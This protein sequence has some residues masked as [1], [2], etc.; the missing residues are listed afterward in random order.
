M[1]LKI[2]RACDLSSISVFPPHSRRVTSMQS[3]VNTS[4][5]GKNKTFSQGRPT[6]AESSVFGRSQPSQIHPQ[7]QQSFSQGM[8][9]SQL[10]QNSLEDVLANEQGFNSQDRGNSAKKVS[11]LAPITY[12]QESQL[13]VSRSSNNVIRK[14]NSNSV[15]ESRCPVSEELEHR[16]GLMETSVNRMGIIL[17]SVESDV[18]QINKAVKEVSI[19]TEGIRQKMTVHDNAMQMMMKGD[20]EIKANLDASL[21]VIPNQLRKGFDHQKLQE[22]S[23]EISKLPNLI[24]TCLLRFKAELNN[25]FTK[26]LQVVVNSIKLPIDSQPAPT[27][28]PPERKSCISTISKQSPT[29]EIA[30]AA[31]KVLR[32]SFFLKM[33]PENRTSV[34]PK[35]VSFTATNHKSA[36]KHE[37]QLIE[38]EQAIQVIIDSDEE[39]DG[40]F[41]CLLD[42]KKPRKGVCLADDVEKQTLQILRKARRRKRKRD[43]III[44]V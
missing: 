41:S 30:D 35:K 5:L 42:E 21:K 7:S 37:V 39:F 38:Q 25:I 23:S 17:D 43:D 8:S 10:S 16:I 24:D 12:P 40:A 3:G 9:M 44:L 20:E 28:Q 27:I 33:E 1:K 15:A 29:L 4:V 18:I 13:Q 34:R 22:I 36:V 14:W 11:C 19:E 32:S 6:A 31:P 2:N 26:E